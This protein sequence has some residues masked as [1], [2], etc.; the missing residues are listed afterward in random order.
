VCVCVCVYVGWGYIYKHADIQTHTQEDDL[1]SPLLFLH[2]NEI[3]LKAGRSI[4]K[5]DTNE[6]IA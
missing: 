6:L 1:I 3:R 2:N 4:T 5:Q